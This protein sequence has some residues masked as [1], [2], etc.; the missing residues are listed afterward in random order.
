MKIEN[1]TAETIL[2]QPVEIKIGDKTYNAAPPSVATLILVS[3]A[4]SRM[5]HIKL[6]EEMVIEE[7]LSIAKDCSAI[8]EII[9]I[10]VL[11]AKGIRKPVERTEI[12]YK[13]Y[14]FGLIKKRTNVKVSEEVDV[15]LLL[16]KELLENVTPTELF[17]Q[18]ANLLRTMQ[19]Q[20]FFGLTTFLTEIN[21]LRQTKVD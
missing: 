1:K 9:A 5:P 10:L 6:H 8:G 18:C 11:G 3:E 20:D 13:R 4:V 16:A 14:F 2:Q 15:K 17:I 7:S 21:L 12:R 19:I